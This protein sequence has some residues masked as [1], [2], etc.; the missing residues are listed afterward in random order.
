[1][2]LNLFYLK[3]IPFISLSQF[4]S[5]NNQSSGYKE[6]EYESIMPLCFSQFINASKGAGLFYQRIIMASSRG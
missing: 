3:V 6:K 4:F 5:G 1:M 2:A